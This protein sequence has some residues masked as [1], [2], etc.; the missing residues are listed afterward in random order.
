MT[1]RS[2]DHYTIRTADLDASVAFYVDVLGLRH[3]ERPTFTVPGAWLYC[4]D[5]P[6]VHLIGGNGPKDA[7]TG[8]IDHVAFRASGLA[9]FTGHLRQLGI[10]FDER[11]PPGTRTRQVFVKDPD[12]LTVEVNFPGEAPA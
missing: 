7:G 11:T 1:V 6:T 8:A 3:G 4:G 12:G 2:L 10:P 5:S 9:E